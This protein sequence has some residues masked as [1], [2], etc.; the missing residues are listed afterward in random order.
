MNIHFDGKI[1]S[2][3]GNARAPPGRGG[4]R[5]LCA[6]LLLRCV[7]MSAAPGSPTPASEPGEIRRVSVAE[8]RA[9]AA[10]GRAVLVD[11]RDRRLFDNAHLPGALSLPVAEID[12]TDG[13]APATA[14]PPDAVAI[15]YCA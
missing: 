12:A 14:W 1:Y 7:P 8:A 6:R 10:S 2:A 5:T 15:L 9:L 13:N 3:D 4:L 11:T